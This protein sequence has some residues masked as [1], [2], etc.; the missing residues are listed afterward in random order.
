MMLTNG[1]ETEYLLKSISQ[2]L[3]GREDCKDV[4]YNV[5]INETGVHMDPIVYV[6]PNCH[7]RKESDK[8]DIVTFIQEYRAV[9]TNLNDLVFGS[10]E[11]TLIEDG[12]KRK[13]RKLNEA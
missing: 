10:Y 2:R 4:S 7:Q 12:K 5:V 1:K 3:S 9:G 6:Y 11:Y 13:W 8:V